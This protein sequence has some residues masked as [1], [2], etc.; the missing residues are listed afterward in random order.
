MGP[1]SV[2]NLQIAEPQYAQWLNDTNQFKLDDNGVLFRIQNDRE[3]CL[4]VPKPMRS[5]ILMTYHD[6]PIGAH[7]GQ[8][9][10]YDLISHW[11]GMRSDVENYVAN[12]M[13]CCE[14][15]IGK[16]PVA[17]LQEFGEVVKP[18]ELVS[19]DILGPFSKTTSGNVYLLTFMDAFTKWS[20]A[21]PIPDQTAETVA[22]EFVTKIIARHGT[23][24][25][26]LT[27]QGRNFVST[28]FKEV[29]KLLRIKKIQTSPYHPMA[30]GLVERSHQTFTA[31]MSHFV[32][33]DQ[34]DWD[35]WIAIVQMAYRSTP[36]SVTG[37]SP[38]FLLYGREMPL[39]FPV[40]ISPKFPRESIDSDPV[41][42]LA[43][44]LETAYKVV[45]DRLSRVRQR[46]RGSTT[47]DEM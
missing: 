12:C 18:F 45:R 8:R 39:P 30:N 22:R 21:I 34:R 42:G 41:V 17:P 20:E 15:K 1:Q 35:K 4:V 36:H 27:D 16:H 37:Y 23:P 9:R 2:R 6:S 3:P 14:R 33:K 25:Q 31:M 38:F 28:L 43:K 26:V 5:T 24:K 7:Q 47:R 13:S 19:M 46:K 40:D 32:R 11:P 29:C 10:T 44:K